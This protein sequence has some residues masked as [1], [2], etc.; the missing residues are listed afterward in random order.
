MTQMEWAKFGAEWL[1]IGYLLVDFRRELRRLR[2]A[3]ERLA[4]MER[5][6]H[7]GD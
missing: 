5:R 3:V 1:L 2:A 7:P 4:P 6:A